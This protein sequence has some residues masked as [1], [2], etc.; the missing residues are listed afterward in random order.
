[1]KSKRH[2]NYYSLKQFPVRLHPTDHKTLKSKTTLDGFTMQILCEAC[3]MA[4]LQ[5]DER[6]KTIAK[7]YKANAAAPT[8]DIT[9]SQEEGEDILNQIENLED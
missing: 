6:V 9:W 7:A 1:M 5:G 8:K 2:S 4:Y 3:I